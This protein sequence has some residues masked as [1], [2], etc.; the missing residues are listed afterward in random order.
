M[1]RKKKVIAIEGK[2]GTEKMLKKCKS[3]KFINNG[4]LVKFPKKNQ[5]I[6]RTM[7]KKEEDYQ[8]N[9]WKTY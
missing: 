6:K 3:K 5:T 7:K 1:V 4:V 2:G 9:K 8:S